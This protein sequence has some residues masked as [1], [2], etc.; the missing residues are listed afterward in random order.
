[1]PPR[2]APP[3]SASSF[4]PPHD[5]ATYRDLLLFEERLKSNAASLSRHKR[6]K[7]RA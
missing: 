2:P 5:A 7:R 4:H 6:R 1:M 3:A